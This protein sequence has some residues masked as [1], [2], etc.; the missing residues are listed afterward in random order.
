MIAVKGQ[1]RFAVRFVHGSAAY[2]CIS[3]G[4]NGAETPK[5]QDS[6]DFSNP[7]GSPNVILTEAE[8][9]LL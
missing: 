9:F 2:R 4:L 5:G 7:V 6:R 3:G 8:G 1:H